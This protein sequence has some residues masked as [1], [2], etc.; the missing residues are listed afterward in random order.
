MGG[1]YKMNVFAEKYDLPLVPPD[2]S[3]KEVAKALLETKP[4]L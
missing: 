1:D 3:L 2:A 4:T